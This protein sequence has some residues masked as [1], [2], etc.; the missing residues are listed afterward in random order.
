MKSFG[1]HAARKSQKVFLGALFFSLLVMGLYAY[2]FTKVFKKNERIAFLEAQVKAQ[3]E[4]SD[5][6]TSIKGRIAD[7][8]SSRAKLDSY[9]IS[10]DGVVTFLNK[11]E[12]LAAEN[13]LLLEVNTVAIEDEVTA[14]ELFEHVRLSA[15][16]TGTWSDVYRFSRLIEL[17]PFKVHVDL[18]DFEKIFKQ[19]ETLGSKQKVLAD[20]DWKGTFEIR[21][22]KLK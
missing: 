9:F 15:S 13:D 1:I 14:P 20:P 7:T 22:L 10:K 12:S 18:V 11:F 4:E 16:V 5:N 6:L 2:A 3:A 17:M 8:A 19:T 21:V